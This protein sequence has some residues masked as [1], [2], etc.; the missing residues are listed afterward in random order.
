[1]KDKLIREE[2]L[3]KWLNGEFEDDKTQNVTRSWHKR[4]FKEKT[5][6][7][8]RIVYEGFNKRL[9]NCMTREFKRKRLAT[10][11]KQVGN[12]IQ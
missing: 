2:G 5:L 4:E 3:Q 12:L 1:M 6:N 8:E 9:K 7:F 11:G 10:K